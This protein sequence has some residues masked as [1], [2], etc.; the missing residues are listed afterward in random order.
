MD[1]EFVN[2]FIV[3]QRDMLSELLNRN[4]VLE[5]TVQLL[6]QKI[7]SLQAQ[8]PKAEPPVGKMSK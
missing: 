2:A 7:A 1:T 8:Q 6:E 5:T 3:K 4:L